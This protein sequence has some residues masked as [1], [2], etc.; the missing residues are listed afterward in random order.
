MNNLMGILLAAILIATLPMEEVFARGFG[1]GRGGFGGGFD[2]GS[3]GGGFNRGDFGGGFRDRSFGGGD[4][5][6]ARQEGFRRDFQGDADRFRSERMDSF[7][8]RD[9]Q[10]FDRDRDRWGALPDRDFAGVSRSRL[11]NFIGM[12][13]DAGVGH[14]GAEAGRLDASRNLSANI[15]SRPH[16]PYIPPD[17][18]RAQGWN[19]RHNFD[20]HHVFNPDWWRRHPGAWVAAGIA[21]SAWAA[22]SWSSAANWVGCDQMPE[23]YDYGSTVL[24]QG[25]D[26]YVEGQSVGSEDQ[27]YDQASS[28]ASSGQDKKDDDANWLPLG[29]FGMVQGQ[30][31]DPTMIVQ[32]AVNHQGIVRGNCYY[33]ISQI[34][35]PIQGAVDKQTQRV[36]WTA[37]DNKNTVFDTG[38]YNLTKDQAPALVHFGKDRTQ[39]WL[40]VRLTSKDQAKNGS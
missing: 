31:T 40:M 23:D 2:R 18:R 7:R 3:F 22:A 28:L 21:A 33:V 29:V 25:G 32:L 16:V 26:V 1:G 20:G 27:Y 35:V 8:D 36:A 24:Y 34:N 37:G 14:L 38:L 30:Q 4:W 13:T 5:G 19:V 12:P 9:A 10:R 15:V 17:D 6:G 39:E 11:D